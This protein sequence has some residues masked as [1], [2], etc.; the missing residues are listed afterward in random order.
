MS[1]FKHLLVTFVPLLLFA[2]GVR[3]DTMLT[4]CYDPYPP[5]T[6]GTGDTPDGGIAVEML[7]AVTSRIDGVSAEVILLPWKRCQ[8]AA[9]A[10]R[11][12]GILPLSKSDERAEYLVFSDG[13]FR[14]VAR[15]WYLP[16]RNPDGLLWSGDFSK[17]ASLRLAMLNGGHIDDEMQDAFSQVQPI[18]RADD[19]RGL[20]SMLKFGRVDL[21]A[22]DGLVG[23]YHVKEFGWAEEIRPLDPP[24]SS[25]RSHFALSKASGADKHLD[26]FNAALGALRAEGEIEAIYSGR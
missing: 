4:F 14:E 18:E 8:E 20:F 5:Y 13:V 25:Q 24:I 15:F 10:G 9:R 17:V 21:V 23:A 2:G 1:M 7:D 26:A 6:L 22:F 11:V 12:D 3:A 19:V 16:A